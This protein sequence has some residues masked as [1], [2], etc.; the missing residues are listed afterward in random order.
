MIR[1]TFSI[2]FYYLFQNSRD[3]TLKIINLIFAL[4]APCTSKQTNKIC[5]FCHKLSTI[6]EKSIRTGGIPNVLHIK[7]NYYSVHW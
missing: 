6:S 3:V 1:V 2:T 5:I 4:T 7:F